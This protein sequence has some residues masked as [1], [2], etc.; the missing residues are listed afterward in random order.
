MIENNKY[1]EKLNI[2]KINEEYIYGKDD[3]FALIIILKYLLRPD[4]FKM[5]IN[6]ISYEIDSLEGKL[7]VISIDKVLDRIGFP[8]NY[9]LK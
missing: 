3:L 7:N 2:P 8:K 1:H 9:N 5:L 6:E 4:E